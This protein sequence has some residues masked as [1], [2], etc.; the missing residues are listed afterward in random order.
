MPPIRKVST[1]TDAETVKQPSQATAESKE[2]LELLSIW[3]EAGFESKSAANLAALR[4]WRALY[5]QGFWKSPTV[6][7]N[8]SRSPKV[9][10]MAKY[11]L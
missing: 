7:E 1:N 10:L 3:E 4:I 9:F 5:E 11:I 8:F 2:I 6:L